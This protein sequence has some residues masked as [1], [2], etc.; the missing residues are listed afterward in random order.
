[1]TCDC[2]PTHAPYFTYF[3]SFCFYSQGNSSGTQE[4]KD[5]LQ[6]M[7][8]DEQEFNGFPIQQKHLNM[9]LLFKESMK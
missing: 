8:L 4:F 3:F 6:K 2:F 9:H 5:A 1:M 7:M